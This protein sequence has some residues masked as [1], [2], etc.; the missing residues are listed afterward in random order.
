MTAVRLPRITTNNLVEVAYLMGLGHRVAAVTIVPSWPYGVEALC[1]TVEGR[2]V[3]LDR[4]WY[5]Q[6]RCGVRPDHL[7]GV[8]AEVMETVARQADRR[9]AAPAA[10][11]E[12]ATTPEV[13]ASPATSGEMPGIASQEPL[14]WTAEGVYRYERDD[15]SYEI[16]GS[17]GATAVARRVRIRL[18]YQG[19]RHFDSLDLVSSRARRSF[20][21]EIHRGWG[22]ET[23]LIEADLAT[24]VDRIEAEEERNATPPAPAAAV[25]L[26]EDERAAGLELLRDP[27]LIDRIAS[28]IEAAGY[29]GERMNAL[30]VYL[31]AT[32][33]KLASPLSVIIAAESA[34]GKSYLVETVRR[35]MPEE[36]VVAVTSLSDQALNYIEDL[37][38]KFLILGEAVH[39]ESVEHQIREMLSAHE[40]RRLVTVKDAESGRMVSRMVA[41]P[42]VVSSVMSTTNRRINAE[43]A[44]RCFVVS[45]DESDEQ[46]RR[47][48]AAQRRKYTVDGMLRR[49]ET[50]PVF[51]SKQGGATVV[52]SGGGGESVG[53]APG[54]PGAPHAAPAG[55]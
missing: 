32:S 38:H 37:H 40:L 36:D 10:G 28:D 41:K 46:T 7:P 8:L 26:T 2:E 50:V 48:H 49:R 39:S 6:G 51:R 34:S 1:V 42:V 54:L 27:D 4:R 30:L 21:A 35:L 24:I 22:I 16:R 31:A 44:S 15:R 13:D 25:E 33:R 29:V 18:T 53:A 23:A 5:L 11:G 52:G 47:I 3:D 12:D 9:S 55:S 45:T 17:D 20:A 19:R 43:N 14:V